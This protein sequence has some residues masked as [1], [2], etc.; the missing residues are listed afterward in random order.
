[1][2]TLDDGLS[3]FLSV[4]AR[5]VRA[6]YRMLGSA[7]AAEDVVQEAWIRWQSTNRG[8]VRDAEAFLLTTAIRLAINMKQSARSRRE[9]WAEQ[10]L[11]EPV[12]PGPE[13]S[14]QLERANALT[15]GVMVLLNRLSSTERVA[16]ILREACDYSYRDIA[17]VLSV[18]EANAR[19]LV[20]RART[21]LTHES[22]MP[23]P[24]DEVARGMWKDSANATLRDLLAALSTA[25]QAGDARA[26]VELFGA[27]NRANRREPRIRHSQLL[28]NQR[29]SGGVEL[30]ASGGA[31]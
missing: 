5:L 23:V 1:M 29:G 25:T 6:T 14:L 28:R 11:C 18:Q 24:S 4:R 15:L 16:Y 7:A 30:N 10:W 9:T 20:R 2:A 31:R 13:Q 17:K 19:Q 21:H 26:L 12:D 8:E 27:E 22:S 3:I